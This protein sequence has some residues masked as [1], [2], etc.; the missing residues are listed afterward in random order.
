[1]PQMECAAG[2]LKGYIS[3]HK[4]APAEHFDLCCPED[5]RAAVEVALVD[6]LQDGIGFFVRDDHLHAL[7][8]DGLL[9][10]PEAQARCRREGVAGGSVQVEKFGYGGSLHN[11]VSM[12]L[13]VE[14]LTWR[15][16]LAICAISAIARVVFLLIAEPPIPVAED[17]AIAR[18]IAA[19]DG[20]SIYERGPTSI[21]GPL[22][23]TY[24][25][26]WLW[27]LGEQNGL[28]AAILM[29]HLLY[30]AMPALLFQLG[31]A[32]ARPALGTIAA[33]LFALHPTYFYHATVA[34][35]TTW[36]VVM[37]A[38]WGVLVFRESRSPIGTAHA[39]GAIIGSFILEKPMLAV[40]MA[41]ILGLRWW[42]R[43]QQLATA[44]LAAAL[45]VLPW[46]V[47]GAVLFGEPTL[48]KSYSSTLTFIHSW[49]PSMA[50]HPRYAVPDS[51]ERALDSL[52]KLPERQ[53]LPALRALATSILATKWSL[54]P[55]R[56]IVHALIFWTIPPRY[57]QSWSLAFVVV[58]I[59]PV[60]LLTVLWVWGMAI[61]W[62]QDRP[63]LLGVLGIVAWVTLVYSLY[64]V[65]N[66]RYKLEVEWLE[67][68]VCAAPLVPKR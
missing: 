42:R 39:A 46:A 35:N 60:V 25:A 17:Y 66:I 32:I 20:F 13:A 23:P 54:L 28:R 63:L 30:A 51:V 38:L 47:R 34:E 33:V 37:S 56:T 18:H 2:A 4:A 43:W 61:L 29:Q 15:H 14:R 45:L 58:R 22:Y 10:P 48:T 5:E 68:F 62:R 31:R 40:P 11:F 8:R 57:W 55:E 1:M 36:V 9:L 52:T 65:L 53:A 6:F 12:W 7:A 26:A 50:V 27:L 41:M 44:A 24:L 64:H 67:L 19:G 21:K 16:I 59:L 49:L 3:P